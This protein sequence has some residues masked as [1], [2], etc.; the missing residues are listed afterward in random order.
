MVAACGA[1]TAPDTFKAELFFVETP[2]AAKV[3]IRFDGDTATLDV[4]GGAKNA[5]VKF[6]GSQSTQARSSGPADS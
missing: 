2:H 3:T 5:A 1:W 6:V 4:G